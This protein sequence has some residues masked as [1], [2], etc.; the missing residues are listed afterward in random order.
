M[1]IAVIGSGITGLGAAWSLEQSMAPMGAQVVLFEAES[2]LGGHSNTADITLKNPDGSLWHRAVD[3]GFIV[4]NSYNYPNLVNLFNHFDIPTTVTDMEFGVSVGRGGGSWRHKPKLEY[5]AN[6]L[7][8]QRRNL[9]NPGYIRMVLEILK[10]FKLGRLAQLEGIDDTITLGDFLRTHRFSESFAT[11][12][13]LPM[14]AAIWS[15]TSL[16]MRDYPV[17][18][19]LRFYRNHGLLALNESPI[20]R[21]VNGGSR[22]Y[23]ERLAQELHADIRKNTAVGH[24]KSVENGQGVAVIDHSGNQ[25]LFDHVIFACHSDQALAIL[26]DEASPLERELLGAIEYKPNRVVL[27]TDPSQLPNRRSAWSSWNYLAEDSSASSLQTAISY[28]MNDLQVF[29]SPEPIVVTVNPFAPIDERKIIQEFIYAHPQFNMRAINAQRRIHE[30][31]GVSRRWFAGAW[32]GYGF[33]EDGLQSGLTVAAAL[34]GSVP[35]A[36]D[37]MPMSPASQCVNFGDVARRIRNEQNQYGDWQILNAA[38]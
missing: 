12:F 18:T 22:V 7:F 31:Q 21:T 13:L 30:I 35:W 11:E 36:G 9:F 14:A 33:H 10:F 20:W 27:H 8:A 26:G 37:I 25:D 17:A 6:N 16:S 23:V 28:Y 15:G 38:E 1:K 32:T 34:G 2:R 19:F 5:R 3:T 4:F 29:E 24:V